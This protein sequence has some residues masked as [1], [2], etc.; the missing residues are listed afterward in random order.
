MYVEKRQQR[1]DTHRC[2][3]TGNIVQPPFKDSKRLFYYAAVVAIKTNEN[4]KHSSVFPVTELVS[5]SHTTDD[6]GMW[7]RK[8]RHFTSNGRR[9]I[10]VSL[11]SRGSS[12][13]RSAKTG[14]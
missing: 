9:F 12:C 2:N 7:L 3:A 14:I 10:V 4:D 6:V 1:N 11:M 8:F 5:A 13:T